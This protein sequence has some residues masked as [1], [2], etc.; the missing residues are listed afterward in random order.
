MNNPFLD[1]THKQ[2]SRQV[3]SIWLISIG[4][5]ILEES[6]GKEKQESTPNQDGR[7]SDST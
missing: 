6:L 5:F 3:L 7:S 1:I 4:L 2:K